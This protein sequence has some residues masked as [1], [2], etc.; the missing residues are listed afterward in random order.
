MLHRSDVAPCAVDL[1]VVDRERPVAAL[2][3]T[4][5]GARSSFARA[6]SVTGGADSETDAQSFCRA[7]KLQRR[8]GDPAADFFG[9]QRFWT[10]KDRRKDGRIFSQGARFLQACTRA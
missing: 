1:R 5:A 2:S 10:G 7:P 8:D 3:T 6:H 4:S 9:Q